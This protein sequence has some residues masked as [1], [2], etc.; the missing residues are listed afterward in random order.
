MRNSIKGL[1]ID[2]ENQIITEVDVIEDAKKSHLASIYEHLKCSWVDVGRNCLGYLPS[3]PQDDLWFD[4]EGNFSDCP[5][6]FQLPRL[7]PLVGRALI[8]SYDDEGNSCSHTL[9]L[10]DIEELRATVIWGVRG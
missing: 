3:K 2:P 1:L 8:L 10:D 9:T 7:V 4:D 6:I 5:Y